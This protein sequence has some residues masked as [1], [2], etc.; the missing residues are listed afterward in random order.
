MD[1]II[2]G[3]FS[4][5]VLRFLLV[6]THFSDFTPGVGG[7]T[8]RRW[9]GHFHIESNAPSAQWR[10]SEHQSLSAPAEALRRATAKISH[11]TI[12]TIPCNQAG[13]R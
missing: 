4:L 12:E 9:Q 2:R 11:K 5:E 13:K 1:A 6:K 10:Y 8:T 3:W 7:A